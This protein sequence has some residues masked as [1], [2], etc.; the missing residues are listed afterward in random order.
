[1]HSGSKLPAERMG[2]A[3]I[4]TLA[5]AP[6]VLQGLWRP[7]ATALHAGASALSLT[8]AALGVACVVVLAATA[9]WR[10]EQKSWRPAAIASALALPLGL[11]LGIAGGVSS[12]IAC[13]LALLAVAVS[14][15][16]LY[17]WVIPRLPLALDGLARQRKAVAGLMIL[18]GLLTV[19]QTAQ[20]ATFMGDSARPEL[21]LV[22]E[23]PFL[24][25]HSCLTAYVHAVTL[26]GQGAENVY[27]AEHWP[28]L[29]GS[30]R[31]KVEA[32]AYA[33]FSLDAFAYPPPFL[34]LPRLLF[35]AV[36][37]FASKRALWFAFNALLVAAGF[38]IVA[39]WIGGRAALRATLLVPVVWLSLP[40]LAILQVG[41]VHATVLV[42]A[43]LAMVAFETR[44]P[45]LGGALLAFAILSKISPGLLVIMLLARRRFREVAWTLGF[46][47]GF[48]LLSVAV[49]GVAPFKA[50]VLYQLPRLSSGEALGFLVREESLAINMSPFGVPFKLAY[51][52]VHVDG[53]WQVARSINLVFSALVLGLTVIAARKDG[54]P[55]LQAML[56][57]TVLTLGTLRSPFAPAY[58][59]VPLFWIFSLWS[60]EARGI[61]KVALLTVTWA[62]LANIPL[63][64]MPRM[65]AYTLAQ[66]VILFGML[67]YLALRSGPR[68]VDRREE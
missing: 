35:W 68:P 14:S 47:A 63:W 10:R 41:N 44:R 4:P 17:P 42:I 9:G 67:V 45:A 2:L 49:F 33:P 27:D 36:D 58:V 13:T 56:W 16:V 37:D 3:A 55:R 21:S 60:A 54:S 1:M 46:G 22:P 38:G 51:L 39:T 29:N 34:L 11:G 57:L 24:V 61:A 30:E 43:I 5:L 6:V 12:I 48:V 19:K 65:V 59:M 64:S 52:G 53:I 32:A 40:T 8:L 20:L 62:A 50:F 31:S 7:L 28:D 23:V 66:Q 15:G 25:H 26:V 18:L